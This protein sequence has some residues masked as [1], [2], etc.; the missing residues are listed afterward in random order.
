M[1]APVKSRAA[2]YKPRFFGSHWPQR[3]F[4]I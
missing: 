1:R 2:V 3:V 4:V